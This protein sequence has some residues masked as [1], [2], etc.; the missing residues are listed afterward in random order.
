METIRHSK[1]DQT[2]TPAFKKWF[3]DWDA[4]ARQKLNRSV[5]E[6]GVW[7]YYHQAIHHSG[8][9]SQNREKARRRK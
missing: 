6:R 7:I 1:R 9:Y 2:Q 5:I 3:G 8:R 4:V